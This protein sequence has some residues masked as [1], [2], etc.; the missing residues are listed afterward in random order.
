[1]RVSET[2]GVSALFVDDVE[3]GTMISCRHCERE[4]VVPDDH[5]SDEP[6]YCP[7]CNNEL[8]YRPWYEW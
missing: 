6:Y 3:D 4:S 5:K 1:M 2:Y 7:R 8:V